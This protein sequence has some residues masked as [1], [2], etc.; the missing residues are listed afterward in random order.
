MKWILRTCAG[1]EAMAARLRAF[2]PHLVVVDDVFGGDAMATFRAALEAVQDGAALHLEDDIL[3]APD[4]ENKIREVVA[5]HPD[6]V[7]QFFSMRAKDL[8]VGAR[9]EPGRSFSMNQCFYLP[10]AYSRALLEFARDWARFDEHPTGYDILMQDWLK[11]RREKYWLHVPSLVQHLDT[12][13]CINARR[14]RSRQ[15]PTFQGEK[16]W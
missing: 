4:F 12:V 14:S 8:T 9:W 6:S 2:L 3:L 1:R 11:A 16:S 13:S 10:P 5:A 15:S 7:I